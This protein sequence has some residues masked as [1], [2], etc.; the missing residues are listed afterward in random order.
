MPTMVNS[1]LIRR[2]APSRRLCW[3]FTAFSFPSVPSPL[4]M[5]L[6]IVFEAPG[7]LLLPRR[8]SAL[9]GVLRLQRG[10][11]W[12]GLRPLALR[13]CIWELAQWTQA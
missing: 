1:C 10:G 13:G 5:R 12:K 11:F 8:L 3:I 9:L 4:W 7:R 6:Q 2:R